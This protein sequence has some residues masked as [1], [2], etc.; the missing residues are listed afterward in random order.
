MARAC[1][2]DKVSTCRRKEAVRGGLYNGVGNKGWR[3][4]SMVQNGR[5]G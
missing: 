2:M 3:P 5:L 4:A 1:L